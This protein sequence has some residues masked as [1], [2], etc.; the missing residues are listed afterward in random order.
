M[1]LGV[2]TVVYAVGTKMSEATAWY[3]RVLSVSP[4][5]KSPG[6][7]GFTVRGYELGLMPFERP[8]GIVPKP[9]ATY[10]G[11]DDIEASYRELIDTHGA[12]AHSDIKDVG[13]GVQIATL[14][15]PFGN[16]LGIVYNPNFRLDPREFIFSGKSAID[17]VVSVRP[18]DRERLMAY[19]HTEQRDLAAQAERVYV[20]AAAGAAAARG[21]GKAAPPRSIAADA[22]ARVQLKFKRRSKLPEAAAARL[23]EHLSVKAISLFRSTRHTIVEYRGASPLAITRG[24]RITQDDYASEAEAGAGGAGAGAA[25]AAESASASTAQV[26][27][28]R[29]RR[30]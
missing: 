22:P 27:A 6:Y 8:V 10:W 11:V 17:Q 14:K 3:S 9:L 4:N 18:R 16:I 21:A 25:A 28:K 2:R 13:G 29:P 7:V 24:K 26:A 12:T 30:G 20:S 1:F 19:E 23:E 15:D 5:F